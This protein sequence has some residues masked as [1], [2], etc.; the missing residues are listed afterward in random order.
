MGWN[1]WD[2]G[3]D[4]TEQN[5]K[6]VI[7]A[8]VSSGMRDAGYRYIN[9]DA[10]WAAPQRNG[11]GELF[12]D[13]NRFPDG[14][15]AVAR[16]AHDRGMLLGIYASPFN[17]GCSAIPAL[18]SAGHESTDART[19]ADWGVDY[20]K[21]DWCRADANHDAQLRVFTTMRD[22]LRATGRQILYSINPNSSD[23]YTAG[24]R[25]D[26]SGVADMTRAT[27]DLVPLWRDQMPSLGPL[28]PFPPGAD[29]GVPDE[30]AAA[31]K[32]VTPSR[33]GYWNDADMLVLG[34]GWDE[35]ITR[36]FSGFRDSLELGDTVTDEQLKH[37]LL[38]QP[39]LTD[40]EQR[41]H[42][43]LWAMLSAPLI[44]G[45][46]VRSMTPQTRDILT[47]RDVIAI[48]QDPNVA[49][50][51]ALPEDS[52][53]FVKPLSDGAVAVVFTNLADA[54]ATITVSTDD[55]GL[56]K[57]PCFTV[58]DLWSHQETTTTG[59]LTSGP[60]VPHSVTLLRVSAACR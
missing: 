52:R 53:V 57:A 1:S 45:N 54:P 6:G 35:Y 51:R 29:R 50:A 36:H 21:Y 55:I 3:I 12:P 11:D 48:D 42:L 43:S 31:T 40:I 33:R 10:G 46:D 30:F 22:A 34:V 37:L 15:A 18:A 56:A 8:M 7:D 4:L 58:R 2:S 26:W 25:Y 23:D 28:D 5:V 9:L 49:P 14:I 44:A 41:A 27:T 38:Q 16:Y 39:N 13:P 19:F 59:S 47:N 32:V 17:E 24:S 60:L 20:L